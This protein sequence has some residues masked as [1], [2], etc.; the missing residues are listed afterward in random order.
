MKMLY[1]SLVFFLAT[2]MLVSVFASLSMALAVDSCPTCHVSGTLYCSGFH[3]S[4]YFQGN[5][6]SYPGICV[7]MGNYSYT[8]YKC[9]GTIAHY[10]TYYRTH[11]CYYQHDFCGFYNTVA[12]H[13]L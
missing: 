8:T 1:K 3:A 2:V 11:N 13:T 6:A 7:S 10:I 4:S 12:P 5:C 9:N